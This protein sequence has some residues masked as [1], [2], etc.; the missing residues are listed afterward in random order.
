M[1]VL[2][3]SAFT[4]A[5][6]K[7]LKGDFSGALSEVLRS[8]EETK[9][10][11]PEHDVRPLDMWLLRTR[12]DRKDEAN[13]A[14]S[15]WIQKYAEDQTKDKRI[16]NLTPT[17]VGRFLIG[18]INEADFLAAAITYDHDWSTFSADRSVRQNFYGWYYAGMKRLLDG[19]TSIAAEYLCKSLAFPTPGLDKEHENAL[20]ELKRLGASLP[21]IVPCT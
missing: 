20:A 5:S 17:I 18:A 13:Q 4:S 16:T 11:N 2:H 14:L 9:S 21:Q 7:E 19:N 15:T 3:P 12:L 6:L 1:Q 10:P 8:V